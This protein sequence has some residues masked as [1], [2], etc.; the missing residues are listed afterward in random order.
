MKE[1]MI[2][3]KGVQKSYGKH[4]VLKGVDLQINKG[5]IYG[6]VGKNGSGKTTIFK[7]ILGLSDYK[8]GELTIGG[9][10]GKEISQ[11]REKIGFLVGA[12]FFPYMSARRNLEYYRTLKGIKDKKAIDRV[13][14]MVELD[15][16]KAP[17]KSF[18]MGMKQRLGIA[19]ALLGDPEILIL[20]E[21][22]NGLDP[23]GIADVRNLVKRLNQEFG[24]TIIV[25]SH[26]LGELQNTATRF[27]IINEGT[28]MR[29]LDD[30]DLQLE[31]NAVRV[32]VDDLEKA[33]EALQAAGVT[34]L[35]EI[36]ETRK[37]EDFYFDL[38]EGEHHD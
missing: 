33:R 24:M 22:T 12:N 36:R 7:V 13:L 25:S 16:V 27:G 23:Q 2:T 3:L 4:H 1:A 14:Q 6:L 17:Y 8:E 29:E 26:I 20:D 21:P 38:L 34:V 15:H 32:H 31:N 30:E 18:S 5:D 19:N 11:G 37:L 28:I 10:T 35:K 9:F